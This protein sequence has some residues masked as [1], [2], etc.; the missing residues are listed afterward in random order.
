VNQLP[1]EQAETHQ[2]DQGDERALIERHA[3]DRVL[4]APLQS[5]DTAE[6][7][8]VAEVR[9]HDQISQRQVR[10]E[11]EH[12]H[13]RIGASTVGGKSDEDIVEVAGGDHSYDRRGDDRQ[14]RHPESGAEQR[15]SIRA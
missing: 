9:T 13:P 6:A 7:L 14:N 12:L 5:V 10:E 8:D 3:D 2:H 4:N 1:N 15:C 11:I